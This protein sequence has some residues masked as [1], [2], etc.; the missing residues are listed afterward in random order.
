MRLL[1]TSDWHLG[2]AL[3][4]RKRYAESEQFLDWLVEVVASEAIDLLVVAGDIFDSATPSNR[5]LS[6]YY[7]FLCRLPQSCRVVVV[8][9]NHD[10]PSLLNAPRDLLE[11]LNIHVVGGARVVAAEEVLL[12]TTAPPHGE[13][14]IV[15][16]VPY[17][18]DRDIR[19]SEAGE[20]I[21][22][23]ARKL[24]EGISHHYRL[25]GQAALELRAAQPEGPFIP[26]V[27]TGH[28]FAAGGKT[29]EGDGVRDLY[30]G[31]LGHVGLDVFPDYFDYLALG[32]LHVPQRV[33]GADNR[34]Y[35][36]APLAQSFGEAGQSKVV[37]IVELGD[38]FPA[39]RELPVPVFQR[40]A[41]MQGDSATLLGQVQH[42]VDEGA[43]VWLDVVYDGDEPAGDL[44]AR[45]RDT[46]Q[47]TG[48]DI[49]RIRNP[50]AVAHSLTPAV[51]QESLD[52]LD[53]RD[54]FVR[55]LDQ[56]GVAPERRDTLL[57]A[58]REILSSLD[59][60]DLRAE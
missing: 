41:T 37:L 52:D 4:G 40:L 47:G 58:Y 35:C 34:R 19:H 3:Y 24:I 57:A 15:C 38:G 10:S 44:P 55:C 28:L 17:L 20:S 18:R 11:Q 32:H 12:V 29:T 48:V 43:S 6:L 8:G 23:K 59:D 60:D 5:A 53:E 7:R 54:V 45:L 39:V 22:D 14:V 1:H 46:V 30:V 51:A 26:V 31:D 21:E 49:L 25:V 56:R 2:R 33:A 42:L 36:G 9:G 16:A 13:S 50:R 27:A